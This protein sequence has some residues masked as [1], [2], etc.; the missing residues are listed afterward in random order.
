[1][2]SIMLLSLLFMFVCTSS[3]AAR[4]PRLEALRQQLAVMTTELAS[5]DSAATKR[6]IMTYVYP[7]DLAEMIAESGEGGLDGVVAAF[8]ASERSY[9]IE[10]L[11]YAA[12]ISPEYTRKTRTYSFRRPGEDLPMEFVYDI[13][14]DI[15]YLR[16]IVTVE[17]FGERRR[18][19]QDGFW[20]I[21]DRRDVVPQTIRRLCPSGNEI[22]RIA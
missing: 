6:F 11:H 21:A 5:T 3:F 13:D 15:F 7:D 22:G 18:P 8:S 1:M 2:R 4:A 9:M 19:R 16:T 12:T 17:V 20:K 10:F 14:K